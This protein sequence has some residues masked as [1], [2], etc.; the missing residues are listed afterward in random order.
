MARLKRP[1]RWEQQTT[2]V[3]QPPSLYAPGSEAPL[4]K[5][6][7]VVSWNLGYAFGFKR[8]HDRAWHYLA[9]LDPDLA[10]LQEALPPPWAREKW[11]VVAPHESKWGSVI[12][13]K[14][15]MAL[16]AIDPPPEANLQLG[17]AIATGT[18]RLPDGDSLNVISVHAPAIKARDIDLAGRHPASVKLP[19]DRTAW[20]RD[21]AY[22]MC[23]ELVRDQRFL[24]SGDWNTS[25]QLWDQR[26]PGRHEVDFFTRAR[27]D[28]WI[29]CYGRF[30]ADEGRTW[31]HEGHAPYQLD[32]A[33][34]DP[35]TAE[36]LRACDIDAHPAELKLSD[37]APLRLIFELEP[38]S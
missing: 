24:A 11:T 25:P 37:H 4:G 19:L 6:M 36:G 3:P 14:P 30:H 22:V 9:A 35:V 38:I 21:V 26:H 16:R 5:I 13:A 31:F 33:F 1:M 28:G 27:G 18:V 23:R 7:L 8:T 20:L 10:V 12:V 29:D 15:D 32:H 2:P 34:C 17:L